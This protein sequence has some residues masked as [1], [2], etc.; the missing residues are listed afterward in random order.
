MSSLAADDNFVP[1]AD[2]DADVGFATDAT[3]AVDAAVDKDDGGGG[4]AF[5]IIVIFIVFGLLCGAD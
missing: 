4:A 2:S 5:F 3:A 1:A